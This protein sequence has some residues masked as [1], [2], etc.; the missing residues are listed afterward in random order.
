MKFTKETRIKVHQKFNGKCAYCGDDI[1]LRDMQIDHVIPKANFF[2]HVANNYEVPEFLKHLT[3]QD[4]N[5]FYNLFPAC[6]VCNKW[7]ATFHLELFRHEI[8]S[9]VKR[10]NERSSNYRMA[11]K[12]GM[13][14]EKNIKIEFYFEYLKV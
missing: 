3:L 7:K 4:V 2:M 14:E 5:H 6:R 13:I 12:Y 1:K 10:L 9:Q 8:Q 11:K